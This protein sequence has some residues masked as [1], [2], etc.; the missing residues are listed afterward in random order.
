MKTTK[1]LTLIT[2]VLFILGGMNACNQTTENKN[3]TANQTN[4]N[5]ASNANQTNAN[6]PEANKTEADKPASSSLA[7]PSDAYKAAYNARQKKDLEGLKKA[8]SK[9]A[10]EFFTMMGD[11]KTPDEGLKQLIERP[12]AATAE[13]RN[14]IIVGDKA[15]LEYLNEK[16]SWGPMDFV[17]E[18]GDWKLTIPKPDSKMPED[19]K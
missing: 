7:T 18:D 16:N 17:K 1:F 13:T 6:K 19:K 8:M 10:L 3:T 12:Q 15:K 9:A 2:A 11:G 4:A 14:E 5:N